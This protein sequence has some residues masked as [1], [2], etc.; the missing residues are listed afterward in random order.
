MENP[1]QFKRSVG[2]PASIMADEYQ[3]RRHLA[4]QQNKS[5]YLRTSIEYFDSTT[6]PDVQFADIEELNQVLSKNTKEE[7]IDRLKFLDEIYSEVGSFDIG[8]Q[9]TL[10]FETEFKELVVSR[11]QVER[12]QAQANNALVS[13]ILYKLVEELDAEIQSSRKLIRN[14]SASQFVYMYLTQNPEFI[15]DELKQRKS[16]PVFGPKAKEYVYTLQACMKEFVVGLVH[17]L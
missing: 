9:C 7:V 4:L 12:P 10:Q 13:L 3:R 6:T 2:A 17:L 11:I 14:V 16:S 15:R 5:I 8:S 1:N